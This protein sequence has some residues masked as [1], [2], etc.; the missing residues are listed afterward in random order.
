MN[1]ILCTL[2]ADAA[3]NP[4]DQIDPDLLDVAERQRTARFAFSRDG[5]SYAAAHALLRLLLAEFH[6]LPP[7][8]W[9]F[10]NNSSG[11]PEVDPELGIDHPPRFSISHTHGMAVCALTVGKSQPG[12]EIG[13]DA[14]SLLRRL[15]PLAIA[16]RFLSLRE[17]C[18]LRG[19]PEER[20]R[21]E[22][23][24]LWTLKEAITKTTGLGLQMDLKSFHCDMD[25]V[26]VA[27]DGPDWGSPEEWALRNYNIDPH[28]TVSLALRRSPETPV[29][30][31]IRHLT[32]KLRAQ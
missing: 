31:K 15:Q 6:G 26:S 24:R 16:E 9:R 5:W 7:L 4:F 19:L 18:W 17:A 30:L 10:R 28:H 21:H 3:K 22:F 1:I 32:G 2:A 25:N 29:N 27:F 13:V 12:V 8:S 20:L 14:E 23:I 11:R